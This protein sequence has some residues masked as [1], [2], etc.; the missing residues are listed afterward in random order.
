MVLNSARLMPEFSNRYCGMCWYFSNSAAQATV[1][2][3][4]TT[5]VTG[6]HSV[7]DRPERVSRVM[8]PITTIAKII[9][10][11]PNSHSATGRRSEAP[12]LRAMAAGADAALVVIDKK[13]SARRRAKAPRGQGD[14]RA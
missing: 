2:N 12:W 10:Q 14:A 6:C 7:I 8:P 5:P 1:D 4:G 11:Q 13:S 3:G 9:A